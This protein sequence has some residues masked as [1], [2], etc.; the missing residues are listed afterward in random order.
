MSA[1]RF[2][3]IPPGPLS[4][5]TAANLSAALDE[6][7]RVL[8][9]RTEAPLEKIENQ[10]SIALRLSRR[11]GDLETKWVRLDGTTTA[12]T[13]TCTLAQSVTAGTVN[14]EAT[15]TITGGSS[16]PTAGRYL[17]TV[18]S[19]QV[20]ITAVS[21]TSLTVKRGQNN[22]DAAATHS[23]GATI[24]VT[25]TSYGWQGVE[26][27]PDDR[28][29]LD[30]DGDTSDSDP[31]TSGAEPAYPVPYGSVIDSSSNRPILLYR[32]PD[33]DTTYW[34]FDPEP[35]ATYFSP[36]AVSTGDQWFGSGVKYLQSYRLGSSGLKT[37][38]GEVEF[39]NSDTVDS[40]GAGIYEYAY[41]SDG[42]I[43]GFGNR[44]TLEVRTWCNSAFTSWQSSSSFGDPAGLGAKV[45]CISIGY[46]LASNCFAV[47]NNVGSPRNQIL[48][49]AG[50]AQA[51]AADTGAA[52]FP[53]STVYYQITSLTPFGESRPVDPSTSLS[54]SPGTVGGIRVRLTWSQATQAT[55]YKVYRAESSD[56]GTN[57]K[58]VATIY[59][60]DTLTWDDLG[61]AG[62][63]GSP[64]GTSTAGGN[65]SLD[66]IQVGKDYVAPWG[67]IYKGGI[68]VGYV[69]DVAEPLMSP[70]Q[71]L[72]R[73]SSDAS[74][75]EMKDVAYAGS[76][77][78]ANQW[79]Q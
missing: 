63:T 59:S 29:W 64:P 52:S 43:P 16:L 67:G 22:T 40:G 49:P 58:L 65:V 39:L 60:G 23:N 28:V 25:L 20:L 48:G 70:G 41:R 8:N 30:I 79:N 55:G 62:E 45:V 2:P 50:V 27:D 61:V 19:E 11:V 10:D 34:L 15:W 4:R 17:A 35:A 73:S 6:L 21:S 54:S 36:G 33:G 72:E 71:G 74:T 37:R 26:P 68:L 66:N 56:M 5:Q 78:S 53:T 46:Y 13:Y 69:G 14:A 57:C 38:Y 24:T 1:R 75:V 76:N 18:D 7:Y 47:G 44:A 32:P 3:P 42:T 77:L 51:T 31:E 9:L 12:T